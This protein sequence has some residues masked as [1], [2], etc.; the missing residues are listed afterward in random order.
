MI[1]RSLQIAEHEFQVDIYGKAFIL[2]RSETFPDLPLLAQAIYQQCYSGFEE[3]I[4]TEKE[5]CLKLSE[6][7]SIADLVDLESLHI[8]NTKEFTSYWLPIYFPENEDWR[9]VEDKT[10]INRK[11]AITLIRQSVLR[12]CMYGFLPGFLY[13][14]GLPTQLHISRKSQPSTRV[15]QGT[16]AIGGKYLGL[17]N[18]PSPG[19]W[20]N[21]GRCPLSTFTL[22]QDVINTIPIGSLI[23]IKAINKEAYEQLTEANINL[24]TYNSNGPV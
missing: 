9:L 23:K 8:E 18:L 2:M 12:L 3:V 4:G 6:A 17:Y 7:F 11:E 20:Y 16:L 15:P 13:L 21:I 22:N 24:K 10:K 19:G 1:S 5:I 14:D